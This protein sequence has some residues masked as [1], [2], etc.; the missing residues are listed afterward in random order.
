MARDSQQQKQSQGKK[1]KVGRLILSDFKTYQKTTVIKTVWH[2]HKD[3]HMGQQERT[4]G[5]EI[6]PYIFSQLIFNNSAK[7]I[8]WW[9]TSLFNKWY[10]IDWIAP[11]KNM[12]R[13]LL[14]TKDRDLL[15]IDQN[16]KLRAK[17]TKLLQG[18][19]KQ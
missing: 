16:P 2:W 8:Q 17:T 5:P 9:K 14:H 3:K 10:W 15:K 19:I 18:N 7:T 12:V 13:P 4:E 6:N 11:G 1:N